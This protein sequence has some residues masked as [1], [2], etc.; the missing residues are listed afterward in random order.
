MPAD[1]RSAVPFIVAPAMAGHRENPK[2]WGPDYRFESSNLSGSFL[3]FLSHP[4]TGSISGLGRRFQL[5]P[6]WNNDASVRRL[7]VTTGRQR[8][9]AHSALV[10]MDSRR[11]RRGHFSRGRAWRA[12][13][14]NPKV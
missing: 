13:R 7:A 8:S 11:W 4:A 3:D 6:G 10:A 9:H 14:L 1:R 5:A 2:E 12:G